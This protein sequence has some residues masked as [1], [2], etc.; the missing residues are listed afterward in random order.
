MDWIVFC[1]AW[2]V[3]EVI[4]VIPAVVVLVAVSLLL[5][6]KPG[7]SDVILMIVG[8]ACL[9]APG[10]V[11]KRA[12]Q[13]LAFEKLLFVDALVSSLREARLYA[14]FIPGLGFLAPAADPRSSPRTLPR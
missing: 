7:S 5:P 8:L 14:S 2:L 10:W 11:A 1:F 9:I 6:D 12:A 3:Y 4:F 13:K